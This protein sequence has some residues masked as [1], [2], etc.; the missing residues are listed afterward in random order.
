MNLI[1]RKDSYTMAKQVIFS[2]NAPAA[3]GPYSQAVTAG[4]T[5]YIS[6]QV[7]RDPTTMK[8]ETE[9]FAEQADQVFKNLQAV[10]EAA[11][12]SLKDI[13]KVNIYLTDLSNFSMVNEVM[14]KNNWGM[15]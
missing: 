9:D 14:V 7:P 4:N 5:T 1:I 12:G 10:A 13:V 8:V 3:I 2:E 11:G 6:G 15:Y